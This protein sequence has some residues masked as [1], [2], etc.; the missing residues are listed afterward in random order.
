M[1]SS[2]YSAKRYGDRTPPCRIPLVKPKNL[3]ILDPH[4]T[5]NNNNNNNNNNNAL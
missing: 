2:I 3:D 4:L 5:V 1:T